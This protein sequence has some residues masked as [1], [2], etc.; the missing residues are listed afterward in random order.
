[1]RTTEARLGL[2]LFRGSLVAVGLLSVGIVLMVARGLSPLDV[3][4]ALAL[5]RLVGDLLTLHPAGYLWLGAI[6]VLSL[7]ILRLLVAVAVFWRE[8]ERNRA[9]IGLATLA[10]IAVGIVLG[11]AGGR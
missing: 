11:L 1:M 5:D 10:V 6:A 8:G 4:P 7:P 9:A 2:L 3:P